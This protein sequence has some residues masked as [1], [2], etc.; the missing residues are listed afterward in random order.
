MPFTTATG[1]WMETAVVL[2]TSNPGVS[3]PMTFSA[4][5]SWAEL[6]Y[7]FPNSGAITLNNQ[8]ASRG[9]LTA[10][11]TCEINVASS[12][13]LI[14]M[15]ALVSNSG[16]PAIS[17]IADTFGSSFTMS[18]LDPGV[19]A[20]GHL[21]VMALAYASSASSGLDTL[22]MTT[23]AGAYFSVECFDFT[24]A[25]TSGV[26]SASGVGGTGTTLATNTIT[27]GNVG[28]VSPGQAVMLLL[29][30]A[31][32]TCFCGC[33]GTALP[34]PRDRRRSAR[35]DEYRCPRR[36]RRRAEGSDSLRPRYGR[37][38]EVEKRRGHIHFARFAP[39]SVAH[40]PAALPATRGS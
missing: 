15:T 30:S 35:R 22:T 39:R 21:S 23:A 32:T 2:P 19:V 18:T 4:I 26:T 36:R 25:S 14:V 20:G 1:D 13:D 3:C 6:C 5:A 10:T 33:V 16:F 28:S 31:S 12:G 27:T 29:P 37:D 9:S 8:T 38:H 17:A 40:H 24:G 7:S 11:G 34:R